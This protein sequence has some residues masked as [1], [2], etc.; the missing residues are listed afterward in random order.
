MLGY[1]VATQCGPKRH[2][3][4][5]GIAEFFVTLPSPLGLDE[6]GVHVRNVAD[7]R[8]TGFP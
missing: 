3:F 7:E 1:A 8:T 6:V 2:E 4:P 5:F